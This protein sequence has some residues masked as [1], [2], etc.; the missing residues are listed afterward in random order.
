MMNIEYK[1]KVEKGVR[2][3]KLFIYSYSFSD[4]QYLFYFIV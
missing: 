3:D 4:M 1:H 2:L